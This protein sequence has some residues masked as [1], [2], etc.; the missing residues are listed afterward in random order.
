MG[1]PYP[2]KSKRVQ[3][4]P[5]TAASASVF[6]RAYVLKLFH[7]EDGQAADCPM[8]AEALLLVA[9][10][11]IDQTPHNPRVRI[12]LRRIHEGVY[13][14]LSAIPSDPYKDVG[15]EPVAALLPA[16][17]GPQRHFSDDDCRDGASQ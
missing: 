1:K 4:G 9:F 13:A 14:R 12:L 11:F 10:H 3:K 5:I 16:F 17:D 7:R 8:I 2:G 6:V 15:P